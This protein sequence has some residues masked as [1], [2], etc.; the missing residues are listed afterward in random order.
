MYLRIS[1]FAPV[2][3]QRYIKY[4]LIHNS[5][6]SAY[7]FLSLAYLLAYL[8]QAMVSLNIETLSYSANPPL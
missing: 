2:T 6:L 7:I 3:S 1:Y 4:T 8:F 5:N